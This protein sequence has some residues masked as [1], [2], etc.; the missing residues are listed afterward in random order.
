MSIRTDRAALGRRQLDAAL[1]RRITEKLPPRPARGWVAAIR[2]ALGMTTRQLASRL[3]IRQPSL[4]AIEKSEVAGTISLNTLRRAA[5]ALECDIVYFLV[6]RQPLE[7]TV[8][9]RARALAAAQV[10][11]TSHSMNLE[12]QGI[13]SRERA[14]EVRRLTEI[15]TDQGSRLWEEQ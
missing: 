15:L 1:S 5:D 9:R 7:Q 13:G 2:S 3:G 12:G 4:L 8:T 10:A 11:A 14:A 6:P